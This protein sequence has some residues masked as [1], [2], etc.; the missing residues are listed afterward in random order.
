MPSEFDSL[1]EFEGVSE[2][3]YA[4]EFG[5]D[6]GL[7]LN[8][9]EVHKERSEDD[10]KE[11]RTVEE[12]IRTGCGCQLGKGKR[13]CSATFSLGQV[14]EQRQK[15][16]E[17]S[18]EELDLVILAQLQA[19]LG[20]KED[21]KRK[22]MQYVFVGRQICKPMFLLVFA[23]GEKRLKNLKEHFY[24]HGLTPRT[25]GNTG[26]LPSNTYGQSTT[27]DVLTF[28]DNF[29]EENAVC[30]P[31]RFPSHRNADAQILPSSQ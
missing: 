29:A 24:A 3:Y 22:R 25:H 15:C 28:I 12:F 23:I 19:F 4:A 5:A 6:Q 9:E 14:T 26:K 10:M 17:L 21:P 13:S 11:T 7:S 30:L 20:D 2:C 8:A 18:N 1:K 31:G 27:I 16:L